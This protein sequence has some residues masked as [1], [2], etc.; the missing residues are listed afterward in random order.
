MF[1]IN[2]TW[3]S[4]QYG[5]AG[6][7][8]CSCHRHCHFFVWSGPSWL[9]HHPQEIRSLQK[10][11][12]PAPRTNRNALNELVVIVVVR[13]CLG[14]RGRRR[15]RVGWWC[16]SWGDSSGLRARLAHRLADHD[17][18]HYEDGEEHEDAAD[19]DG[20]HDVRWRAEN[21]R[22]S[23]A[24]PHPP[25]RDKILIL[26]PLA[27]ANGLSCNHPWRRVGSRYT[28]CSRP[29]DERVF[30]FTRLLSLL[31]LLHSTYTLVRTALCTFTPGS[32]SFLH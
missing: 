28:R 12:P 7:R 13:G 16:E 9:H 22:E 23:A 29:D 14:V 32:L 1:N 20:Y 4:S 19:R 31:F 6:A 27:L 3:T 11:E 5:R 21:C 2:A 24:T 26:W 30:N 8:L 17:D 10:L 18:E 25:R 15:E